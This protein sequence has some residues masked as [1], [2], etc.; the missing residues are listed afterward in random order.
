MLIGLGVHQLWK[1][2]DLLAGSGLPMLGED[3]I[4]GGD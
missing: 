2:C 4:G 1:E 3:L